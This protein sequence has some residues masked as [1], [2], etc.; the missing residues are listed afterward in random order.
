M[1]K[2]LDL[3]NEVYGKLKVIERAKKEAP[4]T[5][6]SAYQRW[7]STR[8][9]CL[10]D[11]G[12]NI[13]VDTDK[14]RSGNTKSCGCLQPEVAS[15]IH[16][17]HRMSDTLEYGVWNSIKERIRN[18]NDRNFHRYGGRGIKICDRWMDFHNFIADMGQRPNSKHSIERI[19]NNGNYCPENCKWATLTE[20]AN[21]KSNTKKITFRGEYHTVAEWA[22]ILN[23]SYFALS[24]R[25]RDY[26]WSIKDAFTKPVKVHRKS[27]SHP[28]P[29][30]KNL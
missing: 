13:I 8:W 29:L 1:P 9:L 6:G 23:L 16:G 17:T 18:P 21:N 10:C 11:C 30:A 20:Q 27:I 12:T 22:R 4:K 19:D 15:K 7:P 2:L 28:T 5:E 25:I 26:G 3:T 14:L 24:S